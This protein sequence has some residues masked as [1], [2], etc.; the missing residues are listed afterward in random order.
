MI[1][2]MIIIIIIII[3]I[4]LIIIIIDENA[5][6]NPNDTAAFGRLAGAARR[7]LTAPSAGLEI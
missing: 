6:R 5:R 2:I 3:I 4:I 1:M 7:R